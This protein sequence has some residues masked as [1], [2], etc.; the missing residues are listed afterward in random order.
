VLV[1]GDAVHAWMTAAQLA[2]ALRRQDVRVLLLEVASDPLPGILCLDPDIHAFH[3]SLG[4]EL[5]DLLR[6]LRASLRYGCQFAEWAGP[7][8]GGFAAFGSAGQLIERV[9]F[10]HYVTALRARRGQARLV[11][12]A[13]AA[14]A[15]RAG[16][17]GAAGNGPLAGLEAGLSVE[18]TD[19]LAFLRALATDLGV[20]RVAGVLERVEYDAEGHAQALW[21]Q[22]GRHLSADAFFDCSERAAL[23]STGVSNERQAFPA[24]VGVARR[25][26]GRARLDGATPLF[27]QVIWRDD[28]WE[29]FRCVADSVE[30]ERVWITDGDAPED[31][32]LRRAPWQGRC[33]ALGPALGEPEDLAADRWQLTR[34]AIGHWLRLLPT[35]SHAAKLRDEFNRVV[36]AEALRLADAQCLPLL[37][38]AERAPAWAARVQVDAAAAADLRYRIQLYRSAGRLSFHEDDPLSPPRWMMLLEALDVLPE[39]ADRMLPAIAPEDLARR[40]DRV[41]QLLAQAVAGLPAHAQ[42]L[43]RLR[44]PEGAVE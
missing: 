10:Q 33:V 18:R 9:P 29:R 17:F 8:R 7:G 34:R 12:Y 27:D 44:Q 31:Q 30:S 15:A 19:Y 39:A 2:R 21:L 13:A 3:R 38:A 23:A 16:R 41:G 26:L 1:Y 14:L 36:V 5:K 42:A 32:G 11:D 43:A 6:H 35:R 24:R 28:G 22:D 4:V 40:M 25:E 20:E 37:C